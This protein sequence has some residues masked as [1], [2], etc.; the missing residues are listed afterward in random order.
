MTNSCDSHDEAR[1][2]FLVAGAI[3]M[4]GA[5]YGVTGNARAVFGQARAVD[6]G[7]V[8][9]KKVTFPPI[10]A[11]TELQSPPPADSRCA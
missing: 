5:V 6:E 4:G 9:A 2:K 7:G 11:D 1:R 3:G 10:Q 8:T